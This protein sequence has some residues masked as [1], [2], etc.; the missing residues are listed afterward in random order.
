MIFLIFS[1]GFLEKSPKKPPSLLGSIM[2]VNRGQ[3]QTNIGASVNK[4][5]VT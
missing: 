2:T 4:T 1:K 3:I 5:F